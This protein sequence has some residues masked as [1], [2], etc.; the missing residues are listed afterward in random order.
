M[1]LK[2]KQNSFLKW[3]IG[4]VLLIVALCSFMA[5][6]FAAPDGRY[7][8]SICGKWFAIG[9]VAYT[10]KSYETAYSVPS[11]DGLTNSGWEYYFE[12]NS[13]GDYV[14]VASYNN[15]EICRSCLESKIAEY[16]AANSL[17]A[18][19]PASLP[20]HVGGDG[21]V[22]TASNASITNNGSKPI[23]ISSINIAASSGW[24][25]QSKVDATN[26]KAGSKVIAI[27]FNNSWATPNS[28]NASG[29]V[30]TSDFG[31]ISAS[32]TLNLAY[33]AVIPVAAAGGSSDE[34]AA[35][36]TI[37]VAFHEAPTLAA[38]SGWYKSSEDITKITLMDSYTPT[39]TADETW[40]ADAEN[41]GTIK[42]YKTGTEVIIA[43]NGTGK[44][45]ANADSS[46]MFNTFPKLTTIE[47]FG[48]LDTSN[49]TDMSSMFGGCSGLTSLDVSNFDTSNVVVMVSMFA[50]CS[51]LTDL[52]VSNFDTSN[53]A[54]MSGMFGG[55]SGLTDLDV[56][57][58]NTSN[59]LHMSNMFADCSG[60][61]DLD[62]SSFDTS[63]VADMSG[64]FG[65]CSALTTIYAG[66][67]W[68]TDAVEESDGMFN[69]CVNL[70]GDIQFDSSVVDKTYA[71]TSEGY[72]T[73]RGQLATLAAGSSWYKSSV[74]RN[75]ITK[76]TLMDSYTPTGTE[77]EH[78]NADVNNSGDITCYRTGTEIVIAGN[79]TGKIRANADSSY[80][81]NPFS[82]LTTIEN[83][84]F[85]DTSQVTNMSGMFYNCYRLTSL[86][87][88]EFNTSNV[89]SM[90]YMFAGYRL[91]SLDVSGFNTSKVTN[92]SDMFAGCSWLTSLNVSSFDTSN[93][94]SMGSMFEDCSELTSLDVSGFNT[95]KVTN[96]SYMFAG[97]S[98][99]TSLNVSSFDTSNVTSMG[100]MFEGCSELTSLDASGFNTSNVTSMSSMFA[101]CTGLT[102]L[103][104]SSFDTSKVTSIGSM[105]YNCT[106]LT[107]IDVSGFDTS[108]VTSMSSMFYNCNRLTTI[109]AGKKWNTDAVTSS[110]NMF[111]GCTNLKGD[112]AYNSSYTDKK[113]AK[114]SG[115]YLSLKPPT[116]AAGSEWYK[117][118]V[119]KSTI[120]KITFVDSYTATSYNETWNADVDNSGAIKCYRT[121]TEI[122]VAGNGRKKISANPSSQSMFSNFTALANLD[123]SVLDTTK[124]TNMAGMFSNCGGLT[125]L[126]ISHFDTSNV[127]NM[128]TMFYGCS[129]LTTID[130]SKWNTSKVSETVSMFYNCANLTNLDLSMWDMSNVKEVAFMF[131]KCS[132]L[133]SLNV[134][135]WNTSKITSFN[136]MFYGCSG[137]TSLD[138]SKWNTSNARIMYAMF[139]HCS[140]LTSLN[141]S[142]W[143]TSNV[144]NMST[145]FSGCS[146]LTSL[147]VSKWNT[148]NVTDMSDMFFS[149]EALSSLDVSNFKT[150]KVT[151]MEAMFYE[152]RSVTNLDVSNWNTSNV[153][154]MSTMFC[155][156]GSVRNLDVSNF[157][158]AKVTDMN[159]MFFN[160]KGVTNLDVSNWNT[161]NVTDMSDMF[162]YCEG[163]TSLDIS[164]FDTRKVTDMSWMF[165][166]CTGVTNI[167]VGD[168]WNTDKVTSSEYM[169][170][171]SRKLP[172]Y[173]NSKFDVT[174]ATFTSNGGYLTHKAATKSLKLNVD[175]SGTVN[176]YTEQSAA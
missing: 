126:D 149:C 169:F 161:S 141:V 106:G 74:N 59:V 66:D 176:G 15:K 35:T 16:K 23:V 90:S 81:F 86:D 31:K 170:Y 154:N 67:G 37:V 167:Y 20:I 79:G 151:N 50:G 101:D 94:T 131:Q 117:S 158:T 105:F 89:T 39:T 122:I 95:S 80:M 38:G 30:N 3:F 152:C 60:L 97:C 163:L 57:N 45:R 147:N 14:E 27:G 173:N 83:L 137:L 65:G 145:M 129:G 102:N 135:T 32:G 99:L 12:A 13:N 78:W 128:S 100:S 150:S 115:G 155:Y 136:Q 77:A 104:V 8:C 44:I 171:N 92:M 121:G 72:L 116:L 64:M 70:E 7:A 123:T 9:Q 113:Y 159:Y 85:L 172:N 51:G 2:A 120:T 63:N 127:T 17:D 162:T 164:I 58:F 1:M 125:N 118:K 61:T 33:D 103:N 157:N 46:F 108:N 73:Y 98:W 68:N 84:N 34:T 114:T 133:T 132:K 53:V 110:S 82:K 28:G 41:K 21:K 138:V 88:S 96:M 22:T 140:G 10:A 143:N 165:A 56:S 71:I 52:D 36:A 146:G 69:E 153:T 26:A 24:T 29:S 130:L 47:N 174:M 112:I 87:V 76:I 40:A 19:V 124:V 166:H 54:D 144:T 111:S 4:I 139:Y 175:Q 62:V 168:N 160:C 25:V 6:A 55:C 18:T 42:C 75:T 11:L 49:V 107:N 156:C 93:V 148:S 48:V 43:G 134:S 119:D 91:T 5:T 142:N 109:Y